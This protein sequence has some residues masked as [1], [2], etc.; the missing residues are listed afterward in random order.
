MS[1]ITLTIL[2]PSANAARY[3]H[4][5]NGP[6]ELDLRVNAKKNV[7]EQVAQFL[8]INLDTEAMEARLPLDKLA[9]ARTKIWALPRRSSVTHREFQPLISLLGFA[10]KVVIPGRA[11][12]LRLHDALHLEVFHYH[13]TPAMRA[14]LEW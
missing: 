5:F 3:E 9:R 12:L 8:S 4:E 7:R 11:F 6:S 1:F 2:P 10:L 14:D 13:V